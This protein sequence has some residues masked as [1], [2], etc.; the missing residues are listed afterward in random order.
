MT[1]LSLCYFSA[2]P[3]QPINLSLATETYWLK[4]LEVI[5]NL[6]L[7][8]LKADISFKFPSIEYNIYCTGSSDTP[9]PLSE[10]VSQHIVQISRP[11]DEHFTQ[12]VRSVAR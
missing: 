8:F 10:P 1:C 6:L 12:P 3:L 2:V 11:G 7:P 9:V 4:V 5:E